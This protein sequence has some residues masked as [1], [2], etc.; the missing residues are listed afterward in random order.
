MN[1]EHLKL[2]LLSAVPV[3]AYFTYFFHFSINAP[4]FDDFQSIIRAI[5]T[6]GT[7]RNRFDW[8]TTQ[9]V[10]HR[11]AYVR[12]VSLFVYKLTGSIHFTGIGFIGNLSLVGIL[13]LLA[14]WFNRWKLLPYFLPVPIVLFQMNYHHNT[15]TSMMAVQN[16]GII[17][18][19]LLTFWLLS[20]RCQWK[21]LVALFP[22]VIAVYTSGNGICVMLI[23]IS[24][25]L[26]QRRWLPL[27]VWALIG[28]AAVS[29]Y[30][31][32][33]H[34]GNSTFSASYAI[35]H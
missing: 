6:Y 4:Q 15:F 9:Y 2:C 13:V 26:Y 10:E 33:F 21:Q 31:R 29:W 5:I 35:Q 32:G 7:S 23:G 12:L 1:K 16:L 30:F 17:F 27:T 22:A 19:A 25:L 20:K 24:M 34:W 18:W 14:L 3:L 11:I 28:T 8:L